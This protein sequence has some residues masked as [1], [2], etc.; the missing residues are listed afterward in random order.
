MVLSQSLQRESHRSFIMA[1]RRFVFP[2][3]RIML[4]MKRDSAAEPLKRIDLVC[5][6]IVLGRGK[7]TAY[8]RGSGIK[9]REKENVAVTAR[10]RL[11]MSKSARGAF[12]VLSVSS[13]YQ[14]LE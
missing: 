4:E 5:G 1:L 2:H 10:F 13:F 7:V 14:I 9:V 3:F 8:V 6:E 12:A 11:S